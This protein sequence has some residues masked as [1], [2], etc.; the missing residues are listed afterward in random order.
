M[1][2]K[3]SLYFS[4]H[5]TG[6]MFNS[7][8]ILLGDKQTGEYVLIDCGNDISHVVETAKKNGFTKCGIIYLNGIMDNVNKR[9]AYEYVK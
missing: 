3:Q 1:T 4:I 9:F 7:N 5:P 6:G 8:C 2:E